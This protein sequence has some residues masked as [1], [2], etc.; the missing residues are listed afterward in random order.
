MDTNK[1]LATRET[2]NLFKPLLKDSYAIVR[3]SVAKAFI[4]LVEQNKKLVTIILNLN[5]DT[6]TATEED[7]KVLIKL[8]GESSDNDGSDS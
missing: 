7:A 1:E 3:S 6:T 4:K 8:A 5:G 2:V